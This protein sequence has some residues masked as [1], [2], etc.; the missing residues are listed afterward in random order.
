MIKPGINSSTRKIKE[1]E[2]T[3]ECNSTERSPVPI[4][5]NDIIDYPFILRPEEALK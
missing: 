2:K 4:R 5:P 1:L 3:E